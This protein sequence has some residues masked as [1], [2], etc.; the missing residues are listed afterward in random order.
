LS[1]FFRNVSNKND[2]PCLF[3]FGTPDGYPG[4]PLG[5][6]AGMS[7]S[8]VCNGFDCSNMEQQQYRGQV[9]FDDLSQFDQIV[10]ATLT[11]WVDISL[12]P[13]VAPDSNGAPYG[14]IPPISH[15]TR[16]G[17]SIGQKF[18]D[19]G[20]Y[21][22]DFDNDVPMPVC[23]NAG[24]CSVDVTSQAS[25]WIAKT[26][27][28]WGFIIAGP[29]LDWLSSLPHDLVTIVSYYATFQL[30]VLYDPAANPRAP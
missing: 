23:T 17:M 18:G 13:S 26:H 4:G 8:F 24:L 25:T 10:S 28:N 14:D 30:D 5:V 19:Q 9:E 29:N 2:G 21:F 1:I 20:F 11:F 12:S 27:D 6:V 22:W 16:L 7:D 15:A 3:A